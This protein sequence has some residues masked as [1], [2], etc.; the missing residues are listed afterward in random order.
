MIF[1]LFVCSVLT[2]LVITQEGKD[3]RLGSIA[4]MGDTFWGQNRR[5]SFE[6]RIVRFT[7]FAAAAFLAVALVLDTVPAKRTPA[8]TTVNITETE[9]ESMVSAETEND[10][11][12]ETEPVETGT[13]VRNSDENTVQTEA[14]ASLN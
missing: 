8:S 10:V 1:F 14:D 6:G 5:R 13:L 4:G 11:V 3:Q 9:T 7:A 12:S 2:V